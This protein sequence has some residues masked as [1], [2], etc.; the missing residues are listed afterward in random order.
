MYVKIIPIHF[1]ISFIFLHRKLE[2]GSFTQP[3]PA[4]DMVSGSSSPAEMLQYAAGA[5]VAGAEPKSRRGSRTSRTPKAKA[6]SKL[7]PADH[8]A[9]DFYSNRSSISQSTDNLSLSNSANSSYNMYE[10]FQA[11][12]THYS[13][14]ASSL[15][16]AELPFDTDCAFPMDGEGSYI[17]ALFENFDFHAS[18]ETDLLD[19]FALDLL[20]ASAQAPAQPQ[21]QPSNFHTQ[22]SSIYNF[23]PLAVPGTGAFTVPELTIAGN[24]VGVPFPHL[25][26][27]VPVSVPSCSVP[28]TVSEPAIL[29]AQAVPT[30]E[31]PVPASPTAPA[32]SGVSL[33][34]VAVATAPTST[35]TEASI[36]VSI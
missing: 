29:S 6:G 14:D 17:D 30:T 19:P 8:G 27:V 13:A 18:S 11:M 9:D 33:C 20:A 2:R 32:S 24:L 36:P 1:S 21:M 4:E 35:G 7:S 22:R 25:V 10:A 28:V 16:H 31:T 34:S 5:A 26:A 23:S 3:A 12:N 15:D